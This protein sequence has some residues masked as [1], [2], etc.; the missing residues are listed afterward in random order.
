MNAHSTNSTVT[1]SLLSLIESSIED[2]TARQEEQNK[3]VEAAKAAKAAKH[4]AISFNNIRRAAADRMVS[5]IQTAM[6]KELKNIE[7]ETKEAYKK[8]MIRLGLDSEKYPLET[9]LSFID[10]KTIT[11]V[12]KTAGKTAAKLVNLGSGIKSRFMQGFG[13]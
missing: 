4:A 7:V 11:P 10:S 3:I 2:E 8:E 13:K 9:A 6:N 12:L 5:E 1:S